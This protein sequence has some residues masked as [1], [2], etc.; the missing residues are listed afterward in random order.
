MD[1]W[2]NGCTYTHVHRLCA[3]HHRRQTKGICINSPNRRYVHSSMAT[4][5][6]NHPNHNTPKESTNDDVDSYTSPHTPSPQQ[7]PLMPVPPPPGRVANLT[8]AQHNT[9]R[10]IQHHGTARHGT[11]FP[12][13]HFCTLNPV[14]EPC[15]RLHV[16]THAHALHI[17]H[18]TLHT[19]CCVLHTAHAPPTAAGRQAG[20]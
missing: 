3:V 15:S 8:R 9:T 19:A 7:A 14:A 16:H 11:P 17:T 13:L 12:S 10:P 1:G 4:S 5:T 2:I 18:Y 20:R 6:H